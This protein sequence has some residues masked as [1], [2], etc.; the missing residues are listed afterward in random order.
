MKRSVIILKEL[1]EE[2][3]KQETKGQEEATCCE[4][5]KPRRIPERTE[6]K[7]GLAVE[8]EPKV[9]VEETSLEFFNGEG[10]KKEGKKGEEYHEKGEYPPQN[11]GEDVMIV[12]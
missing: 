7:K 10:R 11:K 1:L 8:E 6:A 12:S 3:T 5:Q 4:T 9:E 2:R